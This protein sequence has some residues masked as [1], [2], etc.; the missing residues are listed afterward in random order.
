MHRLLRTA[1][2]VACALAAC[3]ALPARA[4]LVLL[5]DGDV[6]K[7]KDLSWDGD[8]ARLELPNGGT[9]TLA[10]LRIDRVIDD[11]VE[12]PV[13]PPPAEA[14]V[15][16]TL[17]LAW[18]DDD[19][20]P[21]GPYGELIHKASREANLN[22]KV[23]AALVDAESARKVKA[24]SHKGA[25]GL[26][27]LMPATAAR[28]GV[29]P[30]QL[31]DPEKNVLAGTR[32]LKVLAEQFPGRADLIL[33]A[34][35]AGENAVVRYGGIPPYRETRAYVAKILGA[36]G[37]AIPGATPAIATAAVAVR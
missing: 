25:R 32:Y 31:F 14:Q 24:V 13:P 29:A 7:V 27:Q 11:E 6:V 10:A 21:P 18:A 15:A 19:P 12:D 4:E 5:A 2:P 22:P 9:M 34:Y 16:S 36:L 26:M 17:R 8:T 30:S 23:V 37:A 28:F 3:V 33:A 35:N 1:L 20:V